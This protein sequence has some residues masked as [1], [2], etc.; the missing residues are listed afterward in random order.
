MIYPLE[1]Y[2]LSKTLISL[3]FAAHMV[4][5]HKINYQIQYKLCHFLYIYIV[6]VTKQV[7]QGGQYNTNT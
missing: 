7:I 6:G 4:K 5:S 3:Y 1:N 2:D